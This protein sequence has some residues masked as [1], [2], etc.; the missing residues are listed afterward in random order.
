MV[1]VIACMGQETGGKAAQHEQDVMHRHRPFHRSHLG[2]ET[3]GQAVEDEQGV[4]PFCETYVIMWD[5]L[6][7]I[8]CGRAEGQS[9]VGVLGIC[10]Q[11]CVCRQG[12]CCSRRMEGVRGCSGCVEE[13]NNEGRLRRGQYRTTLVTSGSSMIE[14]V[15]SVFDFMKL[16]GA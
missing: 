8:L 14:R 10:K 12:C 9:I 2:Q 5:V 15:E 1:H 3:G 11:V 13:L 7:I 6:Y 16:L 4:M